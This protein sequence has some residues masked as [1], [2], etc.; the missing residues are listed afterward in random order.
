MS[1][2]TI[3][4]DEIERIVFHVLSSELDP[5]DDYSL[6]IVNVDD[7]TIQNLNDQYRDKDEATDVLTFVNDVIYEDEPLVELGD[8]FISL[9]TIKRQALKFETTFER[10]YKFMLIHGLLHLC[11]YDHEESFNDHEEMFIRQQKYF[12]VLVKNIKDRL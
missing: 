4:Q 10:E 11:E 7:E 9:E 5:E 6:S 2:F 8:I 3:S 12:D 1:E